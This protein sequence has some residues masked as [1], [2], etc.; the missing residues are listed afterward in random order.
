RR[1]QRE[2]GMQWRFRGRSPAYACGAWGVNVSYHE[3]MVEAAEAEVVVD[4][5]ALVPKV[6]AALLTSERAMTSGKI[7]EAR[8][9]ATG[10][11]VNDAIRRLNDAYQATG[12]AFRIEQVAGGWQVMTLPEHADVLAALHKTKGQSKLSSA[13]LE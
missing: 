4:L 6:E 10:K 8:G 7:A 5:D 3:R 12:R 1:K 9:L 2:H 11:P 13:A